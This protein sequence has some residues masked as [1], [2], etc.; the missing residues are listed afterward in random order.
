VDRSGAAWHLVD[1]LASTL[2][3]I[4]TVSGLAGAALGRPSGRATP[5]FIWGF[6]L[7]PPGWLV[8]A[9]WWLGASRRRPV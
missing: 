1:V 4:A 7:G 5:G 3:V 2:F 8:P 9:A 6:V